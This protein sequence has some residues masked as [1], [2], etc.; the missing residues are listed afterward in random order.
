MK[1]FELNTYW[2]FNITGKG[3]LFSF[4]N[5]E[6]EIVGITKGSI[7]KTP[8]DEYYRVKTIEMSKDNFGRIGNNI[9]LV[10]TKIDKPE[11]K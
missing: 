9:G 8:E 1:I 11:E 5:N 10:V 2:T 7:V 3:T 4:Q 6:N